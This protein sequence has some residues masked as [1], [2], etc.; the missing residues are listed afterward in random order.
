MLR[1]AQ[2]GGIIASN[3]MRRREEK[4]RATEQAQAF[5]LRAQEMA[6][7]TEALRIDTMFKLQEKTLME[8]KVGELYRQRDLQIRDTVQSPEL[9]SKVTRAVASGIPADPIFEK[10]IGGWLEKNVDLL[11]QPKTTGFLTMWN[12]AKNA[13]RDRDKEALKT[14]N[15]MLELQLRN[16]LATER[17]TGVEAMRQQGRESL[18]R[19]NAGLRMEM[20]TS[21][22][23]MRK[24][25][26]TAGEFVNRW[27][28]AVMRESGVDEQTAMRQLNEA[29]HSPGNPFGEPAS[30]APA[31]QPTAAPTTPSPPQPDPLGLF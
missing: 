24:R 26:V 25:K 14:N 29:Y 6:L 5:Q 28:G 9:L 30:A 3:F 17:L 31:T 7:R 22:A 13:Q 2:A 16:T 4:Q 11:G 15:E 10:E 23:D 8:L 12:V 27:L 19:L 18:S 20:E 21:L 1:G